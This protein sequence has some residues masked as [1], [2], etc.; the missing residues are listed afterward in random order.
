MITN[1]DSKFQLS[2]QMIYIRTATLAELHRLSASP[3][4]RFA[5]VPLSCSITTQQVNL[6]PPP[7]VRH[8]TIS[9]GNTLSPHPAC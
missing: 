6:S 7:V 1:L 3:A 2:Q 4:L 5:K 9:Q 8:L